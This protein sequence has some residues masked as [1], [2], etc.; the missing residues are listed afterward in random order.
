MTK[1]CGMQLHRQ[2]PVVQGFVRCSC[3]C[4]PRMGGIP[5]SWAEYARISADGP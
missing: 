2:C 1:E 3:E 5:I 4:H